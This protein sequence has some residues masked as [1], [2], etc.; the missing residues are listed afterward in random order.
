MRG[1]AKIVLFG[2]SRRDSG[3]TP[4]DIP[5]SEADALI[6]LYNAT[7]GANWS[8][9]TN[10]LTDPVINN[11]YGCTVAGG[12]L[13]VLNLSNN[14]LNGSVAAWDPSELP[15]LVNLKMQTNASL[16]GDISG[17]TWGAAIQYIYFS[18]TGVSGDL[19]SWTPPLPNLLYLNSIAISGLPDVSQ[20]AWIRLIQTIGCTSL[21]QADIDTLFQQIYTNWASLNYSAPI[22]NVSGTTPDPGGIYQDATPP[23]TGKEYIFKLENDPDATGNHKWA[24]TY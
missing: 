24:I 23:T 15:S 12:H 11:W 7:D 14:A 10:W 4:S 19:S 1:L 20:N 2:A 3:F 18:S 6:A 5:Q 17:L 9:S 13:T 8:D 22:A 16:T 21:A